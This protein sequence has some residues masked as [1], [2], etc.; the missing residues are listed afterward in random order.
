MITA[1]QVIEIASADMND[2]A[3]RNYNWTSMRPYLNMALMELMQIMEENNIPI[4]NK[5]TSSPITVPAGDRFI[6]Y[7]D[8]SAQL[9]ADLIA[10]E[11]IF[12]ST[13]GGNSWSP[14]VM[15]QTIDPNLSNA[16]VQNLVYF[17]TYVWLGDKIEV[18]PVTGNNLLL[19]KYVRNLIPLPLNASQNKMPLALK[20]PLYLGHKTASLCAVLVA[21]NETRAIELNNLADEAIGRELNIQVKSQQRIPIRRR[22]FR[23]GYK[24][25]GRIA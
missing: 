10:P 8:T 1:E 12:E 3:Q 17:G 24:L 18:P 4:T 16:V 9:P 5:T 20:T 7:T 19:I 21:Q 6:A 14:V 11:E 13:D 2:S 25:G 22:P 15:R 23:S